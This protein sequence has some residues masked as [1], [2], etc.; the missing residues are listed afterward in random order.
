M[1]FA[2][3]SECVS[4]FLVWFLAGHPV[5]MSEDVVLCH[6]IQDCHNRRDERSNGAKK[7]T[8]FFGG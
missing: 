8:V 3:V 5:V 7:K 2:C 4:V 6:L 1:V